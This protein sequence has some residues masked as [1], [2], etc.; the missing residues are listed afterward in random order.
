[1]T[2][3]CIE[4]D[5]A[6]PSLAFLVL[7]IGLIGWRW[8]RWPACAAAAAALLLAFILSQACPGWEIGPLTYLSRA[9]AFLTVALLAGRLAEER[10]IVS[11]PPAH[12]SRPMAEL[13]GLTARERE[14]LGLIATGA[15]NAEIA[16]RLGIAETTVK[17]HAKRVLH[18]L[19]VRNRTEATR[20]YLGHPLG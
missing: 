2:A 16:E 19:G 7:P 14:V 17:S 18:K 13:G 15:A 3:Y 4:V 9:T 11:A 1:M 8:G 12:P 5:P 6:G 20:L 10:A